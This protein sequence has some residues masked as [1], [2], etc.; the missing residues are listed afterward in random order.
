VSI[1]VWRKRSLRGGPTGRNLSR[2]R[3]EETSHDEA[4]SRQKVSNFR[5]KHAFLDSYMRSHSSGSPVTC[6][7]YTEYLTYVWLQIYGPSNRLFEILFWSPFT[8]RFRIIFR[9]GAYA[10]FVFDVMARFDDLCSIQCLILFLVESAHPEI[11]VSP[12]L[13][14]CLARCLS[15]NATRCERTGLFRA[16]PL[17]AHI[18]AR[19]SRCFSAQD[20]C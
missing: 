10:S 16:S 8:F 12:L 13:P 9:F 1:L 14:G 20:H 5:Q 15:T 3:L 18:L 6:T 19:P 7:W 2:P 11:C 4:I 17:T